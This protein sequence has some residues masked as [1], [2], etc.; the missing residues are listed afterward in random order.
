MISTVSAFLL[1]QMLI[2]WLWHYIMYTFIT[3]RKV[4]LVPQGKN[5]ETVWNLHVQRPKRKCFFQV[6]IRIKRVENNWRDWKPPYV[7]LKQMWDL[8]ARTAPIDLLLHGENFCK[9]TLRTL[10]IVR[11]RFLS[12]TLRPSPS[13]LFVYSINLPFYL[14][15]PSD[16][17]PLTPALWLPPSDSHPLTSTLRLLPCD[18][19][20]PTPALW[21]PPSD[22]RPLMPTLSLP[23]SHPI[24]LFLS[25][26]SLYPVSTACLSYPPISPALPLSLPLSP[27]L[28]LSDSDISCSY[29]SLSL[30]L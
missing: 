2:G 12:P 13:S 26:L 3:R 21:L 15:P 27:C 9:T 29:P 1:N 8:D 16:S 7:P 18:S 11:P 25:P 14:T 24:S 17:R 20:P 10:D 19:R 22:S 6:N 30:S 5:T 28:S 23:P 4:F